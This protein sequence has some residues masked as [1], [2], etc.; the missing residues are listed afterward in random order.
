MS[1]GAAGG[2]AEL[3]RDF[4]SFVRR[5]SGSLFRT[6]LLLS[7]DHSDAEDLL[8]LALL[9]TCRRWKSARESPEAYARRVLVNLCHD[10]HRQA[11][12][13]VGE[14]PLDRADLLAAPSDAVD[15][16]LGRNAVVMALRQLPSRQREV[17]VLRFYLDL[18]I[19]Q[20]AD[21]IGASEGT[22][23]SYTARA[24]TRL[25]TLLGDLSPMIVADQSRGTA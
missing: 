6:A 7:A 20:T 10:S 15:A 16:V 3:D 18:S 9:R 4:E 21:A 8:Q 12:R 19:A 1:S 11:R 14:E 23:K 17:V 13:R 2:G 24:I 25:R 22:V 5:C